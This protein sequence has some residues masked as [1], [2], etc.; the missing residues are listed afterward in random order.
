MK[1][2]HFI[3]WVVCFLIGLS[4]SIGWSQSKSKTGFGLQIRHFGYDIGIVNQKN[5]QT[6]RFIMPYKWTA[7][8]FGLMKDPR[9]VRVLNE[10]L[11]ASRLFV[12]EKV[13]H[14]LCSRLQFGRIIPIGDRKSQSEIALQLNTSL[15]IPMAYSWPMAVWL[16][17]P[18]AFGDRYA[19]VAYNPAVHDVNLIG[20]NAPFTKNIGKGNFFPGLG[21][22]LSLQAEWGNYKNITNT[23]SVGIS[24]DQFAKKLPIWYRNEMNRNFFPAVF[25]NFVMGFESSLK[26]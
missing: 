26:P 10:R 18:A 15:Q 6:T 4:T 2:I 23:L 13:S 17:Q 25:V 24:C 19:A 3:P 1:K 20:G 21:F 11:P 7:L 8:W 22:T 12:I 5:F 9:E 16:Y 14:T